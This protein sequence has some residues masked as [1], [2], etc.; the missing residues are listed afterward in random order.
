MLDYFYDKLFHIGN[1]VNNKNSRL[2][3]L[4]PNKIRYMKKFVFNMNEYRKLLSSTHN[5]MMTKEEC[6]DLMHINAQTL[7]ETKKQNL[8]MEEKT[9]NHFC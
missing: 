9:Q 6:I 4:A 1:I 8:E 5:K 3:E 7:F 2:N